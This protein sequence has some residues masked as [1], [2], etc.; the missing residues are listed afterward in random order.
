M[1]RH[2]FMVAMLVMFFVLFNM[3]GIPSLVNNPATDGI[4]GKNPG[5]DLGISDWNKTRTSDFS[6]MTTPGVGAGVFNGWAFFAKIALIL[7]ASTVGGIAIGL[8]TRSSPE[9]FIMVG[10]IISLGL[11]Y[12]DIASGIFVIGQQLD[13]PFSAILWTIGFFLGLSLV[14]TMIDYFRGNV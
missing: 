8:L 1:A 3:L 5:Q 7:F 2:Y 13:F 12:L 4:F 6:I 10:Y 14:L 9:N 11:M